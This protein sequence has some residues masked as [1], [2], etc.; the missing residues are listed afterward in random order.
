MRSRG[1]VKGVDSVCGAG[2][3]ACLALVAALCCAGPL[4][5]DVTRDGV[6]VMSRDSGIVP[7]AGDFTALIT[8]RHRG[9]AP[10]PK[11]MDWRNGMIACCRSGYYEGW[12]VYLHD[13]DEARPVFEIGRKEGG[14]SVEGPEPVT[15]GQWH[16]LAVSWQAAAGAQ[17][18][19]VMRLWLD[20]RLQAES[21][22]DRP[23]PLMDGSPLKL[24]YVDFGVGALNLEVSDVR[25][26]ARALAADE[27]VSDA[28]NLPAVVGDAR[29][30]RP[31]LA[32]VYTRGLAR[33]ALD[34]T[35]RTSL[36]SVRPTRVLTLKPGVN[37]LADTMVFE[38]S[39]HDGLL[40]R[41][42][43]DG[44]SVLSGEEY[45]PASAF[46]RPTDAAVLNRFPAAARGRVICT[47][48][49]GLKSLDSYGVGVSRTAG[50]MVFD[51][52]GKELSHA[53]WPDAGCRPS[54]CRDGVF[55]F[56]EKAPVIPAGTKVL[57]YGY[58]RYFWADAALPAEATA[59][60]G[61]RL[62][63][64][65]GYGFAEKGIAAL[66]GVPEVADRPGEWCVVD[67]MLYLVKPDGVFNGVRIPR[68]DGA[69]VKLGNVRKARLENVTL[70]GTLATALEANGCT[71]LTLDRVRIHR[72]GGNGA[73]LRNCPGARL[74]NCT[75]AD[76]GH[77]ALHLTGG[78][79][80]T[81]AS[82]RQ[83]VSDCRFTRPGRLQRTYT[84]AILLEGCGGTVS[85]CTFADTPSSAM[86]IEGNDHL[87]RDCAFER[88]VLESDD[89]GAIDI[90][91]DPTY[92]GNVFFRNAFRDVGGDGNNGCGRAAIRF[93][94][95]ISGMAVISNT[96]VNCAQGNFGAVQM[97]GGHY[98]AI[99]GNVFANCAKG[100]TGQRWG[101]KKWSE[102]LASA[103]TKG[104][105]RIA[106]QGDLYAT[107]YPEIN[108]IS[109]EEGVH[110][111]VGNVYRNTP[112]R[113]KGLSM[114]AYLK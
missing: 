62:L 38:G 103:E 114:D 90:W 106:E 22:A 31:L 52:D 111:V 77:A 79:R 35:S 40:I 113:F 57:A 69:L 6:T 82:G 56:D 28:A 89:Q 21:P 88:T 98:N 15:R 61:F 54:T 7:P 109:T 41:G 1:V 97:N 80:R 33:V 60:G 86:R 43:Q 72:A 29:W 32:Q 112:V 58:W 83:V 14:I 102:V 9:F 70:C 108:R 34:E 17:G 101:A 44:S 84:P 50:V 11:R 8:F 27:I 85:G 45:V 99:V 100:V 87:V 65:H 5:A 51:A 39:D 10:V 55:R 37:A 71:D 107:R 3:A 46:R 53:R 74:E 93:D 64:K 4:V 76:I 12:R 81:L 24:G 30:E 19:G 91:G 92:R 105:R 16:R 94:D 110:L 75:F 95:M 20:G 42:S 48:A 25:C 96:F 49:K 47:P 26:E 63:E 36:P 104:K 23:A 66:F 13:H 78:D 2:G 18:K 59:D 68:L 73:G 67:D